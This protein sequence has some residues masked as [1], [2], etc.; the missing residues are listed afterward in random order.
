MKIEKTFFKNIFCTG[1]IYLGESSPL[2]DLILVY[3][4]RNSTNIF[5]S[6]LVYT[7][8]PSLTMHSTTDVCER[9]VQLRM[10][11]C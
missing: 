8:M 9:V 11:K 1:V 3:L 5:G 4:I 10:L 7:F 2:I 6:Q